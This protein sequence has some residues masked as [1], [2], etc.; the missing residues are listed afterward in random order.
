MRVMIDR[1]RCQGNAQCAVVAPRVFDTDEE[2]YGI[3]R[4]RGLVP[5]DAKIDAVAALRACPEQAIVVVEPPSSQE[6]AT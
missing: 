2:G 3:V 5:E 1:R 4:H 6:R